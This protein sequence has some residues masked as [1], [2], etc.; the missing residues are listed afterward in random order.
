M[1]EIT[2]DALAVLIQR[3]IDGQTMLR[4]DVRQMR[5]KLDRIERAIHELQR[6]DIDS[7]EAETDVEA[8]IDALTRR[9]ERLG[10]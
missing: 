5:R 3:G 4:T 1:A 10:G 8:Q 2:L 9:V 6:A 7:D